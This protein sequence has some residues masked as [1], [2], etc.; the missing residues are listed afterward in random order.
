MPVRKAPARLLILAT[1][2]FALRASAQPSS[3]PAGQATPGGPPPST[4]PRVWP[5]VVGSLI[6]APA[7]GATVYW[8]LSGEATSYGYVR[9]GGSEGEH[10]FGKPGLLFIPIL[11]PL[12]FD[13]S[14]CSDAH[15]YY[16]ARRGGEGDEPRDACAGSFWTIDAAVQAI[17]AAFIV[18]GFAYPVEHPAPE[19]ARVA[20][21]PFSRHGFVGLQAG[22]EF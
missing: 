10:D 13:L 12:A 20:I 22:A 7:Y 2:L 14:F 15:D 3:A 17:G 6:F 21:T 8:A 18:A 16:D 4:S 9:P 1:A 19:R 5:I 11:G